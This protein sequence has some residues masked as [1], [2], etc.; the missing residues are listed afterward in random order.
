MQHKLFQFNIHFIYAN[1][2]MDRVN[3]LIGALPFSSGCVFRLSGS[4]KNLSTTC[5]RLESISACIK[6]W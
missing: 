3:C 4:G 1:D 6:A 2:L 5:F